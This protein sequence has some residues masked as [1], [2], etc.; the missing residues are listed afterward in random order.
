MSWREI[1]S[2]EMGQLRPSSLSRRFRSRRI[3][4]LHLS[5]FKEF[6]SPHRGAV[7]SLQV[8][9]FFFFLFGECMISDGR[10]WYIIGSFK[11]YSLFHYGIL[12]FY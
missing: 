1:T 4:S 11:L 6:V 2:R 8:P 5:N 9:L 10:N 3:S 7:N 12:N